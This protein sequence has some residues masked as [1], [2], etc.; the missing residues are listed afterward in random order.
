MIK[1]II[2]FVVEWLFY[3]VY[4]FPNIECKSPSLKFR[5]LLSVQEDK[6]QCLFVD[7]HIIVIYD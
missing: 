4:S 2:V 7:I 1:A 6:F 5:W 3:Y